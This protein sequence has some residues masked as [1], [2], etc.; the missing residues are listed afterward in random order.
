MRNKEILFRLCLTVVVLVIVFFIFFKLEIINFTLAEE[1]IILNLNQHKIGMKVGSSYQLIADTYR[2]TEV[3]NKI[4][5]ESSD[6]N[7]A[8][9]SKTGFVKA[10]KA[11]TV[12]IKSKLKLN[13]LQDEC[14]I[15]VIEGD[16]SI[17]DIKLANDKINLMVG[18]N[19]KIKYNLVPNNTTMNSVGFLSSDE[20]IVAVTSDGTIT[21]VNPGLAII[22]V[23]SHY[24]NISDKVIVEVFDVSS[25]IQKISYNDDIKLVVNGKYLLNN[26]S[27]EKYNITWNSIDSNIAKV[28]ENGIIEGV[29]LGETYIVGTYI[30]G[31][32][33]LFK[34]VVDYKPISIKGLNFKTDQ[35]SVNIGSITKVNVEINPINATN[36]GLIWKSNNEN[37][38]TVDKVGNV[39]PKRIG[40]GLLTV[41]TEDGKYQKSITVRVVGYENNFL[42]SSIK[43][44]SNKMTLDLGDTLNLSSVSNL[45]SLELNKIMCHSSDNSV[46]TCKNGFVETIGKGNAIITATTINGY[47]DAM[48]VEV[49]EVPVTGIT[50]NDNKKALKVGQT[51]ALIAA[52]IPTKASIK[53]F[54]GVLQMRVLLL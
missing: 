23:Y 6:P 19:F 17:E 41:I 25:D 20:K 27:E 46:V 53:I 12:V 15:E 35:I 16:T 24:G 52:I 18:S 45:E 21:G 13:D 34:V 32:T 33:S 28:S 49:K 47:K 10:L 40:E 31:T 4:T 1:P 22:T 9:V 29:G 43:F 11:G 36:Q 2:S 51:S 44:S 14:V 26:L 37:I 42:P 5:W 48:T 8:K 7:I 30:D 3:N 38:F 39:N 54:Y 50:L